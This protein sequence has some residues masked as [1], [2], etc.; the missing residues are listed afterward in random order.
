MTDTTTSLAELTSGIRVAMLATS[1]S[2]GIESRP[3]TVQ[4]VEE[5]AVW[6]LVGEGTDWLTDLG[7]PLNLTFV[8]D[9][10][11]VSASGTAALVRDQQVLDD[12]GDPVSDAWFH[13][14]SSPVA[15]R[16]DVDHGDWWTAPSFVRAALGVIKSKASGTQPDIGER[17]QVAS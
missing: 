11:W 17:G 14:G 2:R 5:G 4:K 6:F 16:F 15:L 10:T 7:G 12:L 8:D 9:K 3:L 1:G 13:E